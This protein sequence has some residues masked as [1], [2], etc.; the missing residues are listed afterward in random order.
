[1]SIESK[2]TPEDVAQEIIQNA[3]ARHRWGSESGV[4]QRDFKPIVDVIQ[5]IL[6]VLTPEQR[7]QVLEKVKW[8][9]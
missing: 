7:Q 2:P 9:R 6:E 1:M 4:E 3:E 8:P 5:A